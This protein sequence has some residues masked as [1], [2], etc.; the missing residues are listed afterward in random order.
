[1]ILVIFY[2]TSKLY[3]KFF[4]L[5]TFI[6]YHLNH[7][8][9][10]ANSPWYNYSFLIIIIICLLTVIWFQ[11]S[12]SCA[13]NVYTIIW[14]QVTFLFIN[15]HFSHTAMDRVTPKKQNPYIFVEVIMGSVFFL[16]PCSFKNFNL[17]LIIC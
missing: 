16:S 8:I 4:L 6:Y 5:L 17:S 10:Q 13:K 7:H 9:L 3:T 11:V 12:L 2:K 1:M 14:V 15:N